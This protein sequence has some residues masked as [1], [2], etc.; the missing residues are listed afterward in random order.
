ML[1]CSFSGNEEKSAH[2][3]TPSRLGA[4]RLSLPLLLSHDVFQ[5]LIY[6]QKRGQTGLKFNE[7][8]A[9]SKGKIPSYKEQTMTNTSP[10]AYILS[11]IHSNFI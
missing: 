5:I 8:A 6:L 11:Y 1:M 2:P 10:P 9:A 3:R 7:R 4:L